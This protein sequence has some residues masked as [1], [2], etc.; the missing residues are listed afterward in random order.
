M[1][2]INPS[3]KKT[4]G[5]V[6]YGTDRENEVSKIFRISLGSNKRGRFQFKQTFEFSGMYNEIRPAKLTNRCAHSN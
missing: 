4:T 6:I 3:K 5:S 1:L 2:A